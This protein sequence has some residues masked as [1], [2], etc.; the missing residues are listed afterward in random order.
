MW[1]GSNSAATAPSAD[2][3]PRQRGPAVLCRPVSYR[4]VEE[5]WEQ[6]GEFIKPG[7]KILS[8]KIV[9][10]FKAIISLQKELVAFLALIH[11]RYP[12]SL[13]PFSMENIFEDK[14]FVSVQRQSDE[15]RYLFYHFPLP[16]PP[17]L[18][19][20]PA[21]WWGLANLPHSLG[22]HLNHME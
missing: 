12:T 16:P 7:T 8:K 5:R 9:E 11:V 4:E 19:V 10:E 14:A 1:M 6:K 2:C 18:G 22:C 20:P 15:R 13:D 17:R 21:T 3:S